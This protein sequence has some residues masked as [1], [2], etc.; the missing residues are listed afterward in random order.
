METEKEVLD[1][2]FHR[3]KTLPNREPS[4]A[5][6]LCGMVC[7]WLV[8]IPAF[9]LALSGVEFDLH[10]L[11]IP[12]ICALGLAILLFIKWQKFA[13]RFKEQG[14]D[15]KTYSPEALER[16]LGKLS[17]CASSFQWTGTMLFALAVGGRSLFREYVNTNNYS[18]LVQGS[19]LF[20]FLLTFVLSRIYV[21][22]KKRLEEVKELSEEDRRFLKHEYLGK[23]L[24]PHFFWICSCVFSH[25][26]MS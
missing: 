16:I 10:R 14:K 2:W 1:V 19:C 15:I 22:S 11:I 4:F 20:A 5:S 3:V 6:S 8:L 13:L 24:F 26:L 25:V 18:L 12:S 23:F 7:L 21:Y 9:I 17:A